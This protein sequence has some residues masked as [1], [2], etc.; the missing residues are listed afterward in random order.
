MKTKET[1]HEGPRVLVHDNMC[2]GLIW[3]QGFNDGNKTSQK[4][5]PAGLSW[6][7]TTLHKGT[8]VEQGN[9]CAAL[10]GCVGILCDHKHT[11]TLH[12]I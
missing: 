6:L 5:L 3:L 1:L 7:S 9:P 10:I 12:G 4:M 8:W 11:K 2:A